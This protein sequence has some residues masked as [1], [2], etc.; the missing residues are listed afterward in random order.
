MGRRGSQSQTGHRKQQ[1]RTETRHQGTGSQSQTRPQGTGT[2]HG[3]QAGC[4]VSC[5]IRLAASL[6]HPGAICPASRP[7]DAPACP[8]TG[9]GP[10]TTPPQHRT[11]AYS[12]YVAAHTAITHLA[13]AGIDLPT[14]KRISG[15]K[16]LAMVERY[17]HQNGSPSRRR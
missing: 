13:Q 9:S 12:A 5:R 2:P 11:N 16:T 3:D 14:V 6:A 15:H 8:S 17:S 1:S 10:L 7:G 4:H